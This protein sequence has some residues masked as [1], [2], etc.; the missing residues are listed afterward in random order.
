MIRR[1]TAFLFSALLAAALTTSVV[2]AAQDR[3]APDARPPGGPPSEGRVPGPGGG[4][5]GGPASW[6]EAP[7]WNSPIVQEL[8][9]TDAQ[10][11][12]IRAT[13][14]DQRNRLIDLRSSVIKAE[15]DLEDVFSETT[16][17]Q[18]K[19]NEAIERLATSRADMTRTLSQM[20]LKIRAILTPEQWDQLQKR[21]PRRGLRRS[22]AGPPPDGAAA[23]GRGERLRNNIKS[24]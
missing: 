13:V 9:L 6:I 2:A 1:R 15:Q 11:A 8:N 19:A 7:W 22:P 21:Q 12:D 5:G 23:F 18:K 10:R 3:N 20:S 16:V 4:P 14:R 24:K 17:D